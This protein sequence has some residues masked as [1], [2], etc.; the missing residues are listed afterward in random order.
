MT[1]AMVEPLFTP[2]TL[3]ALALPNRIVMAPMTR[4]RARPDGTATPEM[5]D[6]YA[7]RASA[8]L[9]ISEGIQP[10]ADG[11]GYC[12]TPGLG[13]P[14]QDAAWGRVTERTAA[15]GGGMVAQLMHVGR[16]ASW[17]NKAPGARTLAPSAVRAAGEIYTDA[18]GMTAFDA[19]EE[20]SP[21]DIAATIEAYA[22]AA[23]SAVASG[24]AGVELHA[25]SGY[26]P[27]QFL[28]TGVNR[29]RDAY[30]GSLAGRLRFP[31]DVLEAMAAAIG[32]E[33]VGLRIC[34]G[35]PFNDLSDADP[36]ETFSAFLRAI[37]PMRLAYL[38][39]IRLPAAGLDNFALARSCFDGPLVFNESFTSEEAAR[40]IADGAC[41]AVSFGR[42]F[43]ANP[44]LPARIRQGAPLV[45]FDARRLYTPG[46]AGYSDYPTL[47]QR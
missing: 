10:N 30:G 12:R 42:A 6:Y 19:P 28:S 37:S 34:P 1:Q 47:P 24:F 31:V 21:A 43:I 2:V 44:D 17:R 4:S 46:P 40:F 8:G 14:E 23:R 32:A 36:G 41:A 16:I 18:A 9:M 20:M 38:H 27:A 25:A 45:R 15:A 3:G 39:V 11:Q 22:R 5:A 26:L 33:R 13:A 7:Q 35:N 29:R